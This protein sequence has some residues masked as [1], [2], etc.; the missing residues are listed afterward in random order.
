MQILLQDFRYALRQL[1]KSPGFSLVV[2]VTLALGMGANTA[3][4]TLVHSVL[5]RSLPV[6][7]PTELYRIGD[8]NDCCV[9]GGFFDGGDFG[10]FSY[11]LYLHLR[12]SAPEF[13]QLA[14]LQSN[15]GN[16]LTVR[17]GSNVAKP[18]TG[19]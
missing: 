19:E 7:D 18:L 14:A 8:K 6:G 11:D 3:I 2:V 15:G 13:S 4:F 5:L 16:P 17:R 12:D 10:M 9:Q 1:R